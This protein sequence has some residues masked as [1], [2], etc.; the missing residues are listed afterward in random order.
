MGFSKVSSIDL[1]RGSL[2]DYLQEYLND[3]F[4]GSYIHISLLFF[5]NSSQ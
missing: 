1:S 3:S 4:R 2:R 5:R